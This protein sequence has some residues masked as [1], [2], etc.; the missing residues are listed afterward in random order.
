MHLSKSNLKCVIAGCL[1]ILVTAFVGVLHPMWAA[2]PT[3]PTVVS[4][5]NPLQILG[6]AGE[7]FRFI[8]T[9]ETTCGKYVIA[10]AIIPAGTGPMPHIHIKTNEWFYTPDGGITLEMGERE[11]KSIQEIP[12]KTAPKDILR[13]QE[14]QPG[15]IHYGAK[16][17][18]HGFMNQTSQSK[19]LTFVWAPD[20]GVTDYFRAVGQPLPDYDNPPPINPKNK[21]L[22]VSQAPKYGINQSSSFFQYVENVIPPNYAFPHGSHN[23]ELQ[24]LIANKSCPAKR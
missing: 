9:G 21:E 11:Y 20:L 10:E 15:D 19:R 24:A 18:M 8:K 4:D 13:L 7:Q 22:F 1:A 16:G 12:G 2:E 17:I 3:F 23:Q 14:T 6:P 5:P